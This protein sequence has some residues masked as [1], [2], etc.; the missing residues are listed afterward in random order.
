MTSMPGG[1]AGASAVEASATP[2]LA[3]AADPSDAAPATGLTT[4]AIADG[5]ASPARGVAIPDDIAPATLGA[6]S[7]AF[8]GHS[9]HVAT[10]AAMPITAIDATMAMA[11][12]CDG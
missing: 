6:A 1:A 11:V 7:P 4:A 5:A 12:V 9:H 3:A 8:R 10:S 2:C